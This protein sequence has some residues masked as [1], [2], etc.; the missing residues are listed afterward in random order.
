MPIAAFQPPYR[1]GQVQLLSMSLMMSQE[2]DVL[3][4]W[5]QKDKKNL[6]VHPIAVCAQDVV[7]LMK[8]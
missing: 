8:L 6:R 7:V 3:L 1:L 4:Y 2:W 5:N